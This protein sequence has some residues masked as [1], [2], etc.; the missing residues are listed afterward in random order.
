MDLATSHIFECLRPLVHIFKCTSH[1]S[2]F[3]MLEMVRIHCLNGANV[4]SDYD[5]WSTFAHGIGY[6]ISRVRSLETWEVPV[7]ECHVFRC[8][9]CLH[10]CLFHPF[11]KLLTVQGSFESSGAWTEA[12]RLAYALSLL[13]SSLKSLHERYFSRT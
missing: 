4:S 7:E 8:H 3:G 11:P 5:R 13:G 2:H 1:I 10:S 6:V 12:M 9:S